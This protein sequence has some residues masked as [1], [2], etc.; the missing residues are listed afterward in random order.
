[1]L[2]SC[3]LYASELKC[4]RIQAVRVCAYHFV[5]SSHPLAQRLGMCQT[6]HLNLRVQFCQSKGKKLTLMGQALRKMA[7]GSQ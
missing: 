3:A 1:M 5:L 4:R 2:I 6:P 7:G